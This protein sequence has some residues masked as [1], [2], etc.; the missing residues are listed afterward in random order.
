MPHIVLGTVHVVLQSGKSQLRLDHPEL[1]QVAGCVA[2]LC[3]ARHIVEAPQTI[4]CMLFERQG[5]RHSTSR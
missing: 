2:V 4:L 3:P 1:R 5:K